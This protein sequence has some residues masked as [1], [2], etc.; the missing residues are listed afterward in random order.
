ML[1]HIANLG[2][3]CLKRIKLDLPIIP[4][5]KYIANKNNI[6]KDVQ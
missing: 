2:V 5:K 6:V 4:S 1:H 3:H